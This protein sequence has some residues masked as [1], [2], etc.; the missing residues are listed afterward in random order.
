[1]TDISKFITIEGIDGSGKSTF[2]P[3]IQKMLE[4]HGEQVVLTREPG[5]TPFAETLRG[6]ILNTNMDKKTEVLLTF[7][8]RNEH[9]KDVIRP[10]LDEGKIVISD[11]FTDS[12]YAYQ[13]YATGVPLDYIELLEQM[14]QQEIKP[15]LTFIF[16]V[17]TEVS[18]QRLAKTG[19]IPDRFESQQEDFFNRALEGYQERA[20]NDPKRC[21]LID[22]SLSIEH[23]RKQVLKYM[24]EFINGL[25]LKNKQKL[26]LK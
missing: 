3:V 24:E 26:K 2:I 23:T 18:K 7:A 5:G 25:D 4:E 14:V 19:K 13:G 15:A 20:K 6:H 11:R 10:A 22:S 8:A 21:K 12:T 1:M 16:V 17:P 9:I